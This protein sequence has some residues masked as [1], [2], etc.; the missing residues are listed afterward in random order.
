MKVLAINSSH[1][2]RRGCTQILLDKIAAGVTTSGGEFET[3]VLADKK[4]N[5]CLACDYCSKPA[6]MG[7]CV[8]EE[9]DD[10]KEIIDR[11]RAADIVV[12]AAPVYVFNVTGMMKM[13]LDRLNSTGVEPGL[14][15]S[16]SG[17]IF[18]RVD[19][20]VTGKPLVILTLCANIEAETVK[21]VVA[22]FKTYAK[23]LD[24]PIVGTLVR[25]MS[26][27][28]EE[29]DSARVASVLEAYVQSGRE[30][31]TQGK[32]AAGTERKANQALLGIPFLDFL[33]N[34][35]FFKLQALKNA[36]QAKN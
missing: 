5:S 29:T 35:K 34:F 14:C 16:D 23:F 6:T 11:M 19:R 18:H 20:Q 15:L 32:I 10:M 17:L 8:Y 2:G 13:F 27:T 33:M 31:A 4:I 26:G 28:L 24:A 36:N 30:L 22:Y 9:K 1:R 7:H 12:Y 21:N 3:V 25:R